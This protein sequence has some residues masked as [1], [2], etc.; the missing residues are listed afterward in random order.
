[1]KIMS[2]AKYLLALEASRN[3]ARAEI[4]DSV[5]VLRDSLPKSSTTKFNVLNGV[6]LLIDSSW[7]VPCVEKRKKRAKAEE[8]T[9]DAQ[10]DLERGFDALMQEVPHGPSGL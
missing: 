10:A 8:S 6:L 7:P 2:D 3:K 1:M 9:T 4:F 5:L